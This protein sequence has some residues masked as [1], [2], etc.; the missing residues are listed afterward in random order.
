MNNDFVKEAVFPLRLIFWGG[1]LCIFDF[2]ISQTSNGRGFKFDLLNDALGT[3][4]IAVGVFRLAS[5]PV[6]HRYASLMRFVQIV[7]VLAVLDALRDHIVMPLPEPFAFALNLFGLV[8]LVAIIAFCV[9]MRWFCEAAKLP[10][11]AQS[12]RVTTALFVVI[13]LLPLGL[14]HLAG[15]W[16]MVS[17]TTF[18]FDLGLAGLLLIPVFAIP[19]VHLFFSTSRMQRG[20]DAEG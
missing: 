9:A 15:L 5:I 1:L 20:A 7:S 2:T 10:A 16:A 6:H 17:G 19:V 3:I 8:C 4:L 11:A 13:Y 12:W 14:L 18:N